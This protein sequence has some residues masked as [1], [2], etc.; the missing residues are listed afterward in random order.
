MM[1]S[2]GDGVTTITWDAPATAPTRQIGLVE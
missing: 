1:Q 2:G